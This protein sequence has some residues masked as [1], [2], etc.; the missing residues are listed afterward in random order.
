MPS[1]LDSLPP[2][3]EVH[4]EL[5]ETLAR[6]ATL[7]KLLRLSQRAAA[8]QQDQH[9]TPLDDQAPQRPTEGQRDE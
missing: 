7:R 9:D 1:A 4:R 5:L 6:A 3:D 8:S 2:P